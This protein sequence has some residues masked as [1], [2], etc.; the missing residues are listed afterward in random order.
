MWCCVAW[1]T[2]A[3]VWWKTQPLFSALKMEAA[4]FF[5]T[6][7]TTYQT[8]QCRIPDD[9][10]LNT[11]TAILCHHDETYITLNTVKCHSHWWVLW[12]PQT[13]AATLPLQNACNQWDTWQWHVD[14]STNQGTSMAGKWKVCRRHQCHLWCSMH[15]YSQL[16]ET[17]TRLM[18]DR[19]DLSSKYWIDTHHAECT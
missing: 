4:G 18:T 8:I 1:Q 15:L 14:I 6:V 19:H 9:H 2:T 12:C 3:N 13:I 5:K 16:S 7:V 11:R 17:Y 10:S